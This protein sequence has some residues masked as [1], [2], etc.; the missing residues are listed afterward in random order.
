MDIREIFHQF[1]LS[2]SDASKLQSCFQLQTFQPG[3]VI[4]KQGDHSDSFFCVASGELAVVLDNADGTET[5]LG[6]LEPGQFFGEIG[7]MQKVSR[8]GTVRALTHTKIYRAEKTDFFELLENS[9]VLADFIDKLRLERQLS[10]IPAFSRLEEADLEQIIAVQRQE[11]ISAGTVLCSQ[12]HEADKLFIITQGRARVSRRETDGSVTSMGERLPG[13]HYGD[14]PFFNGKNHS[15]DVVMEEDGEVLIL[16]RKSIDE[17]VRRYPSIAAELPV[18]KSLLATILPF[19]YDKSAYFAVPTLSMNRP[20]LILWTMLSVMFVLAVHAIVPSIWPEQFPIYNGLKVDTDP[21]NML[22]EDEPARVLHNRL[23]QEMNLY[24]LMVVGVV[25][26]THPDGIYNPESLKRIHELTEFAARQHWDSDDGESV[27]GVVS[28]DI[29]SPS[30]VDN[31]G[32]NGPGSISFSWLMPEPPQSR[33]GAL[34]VR[35]MIKRLPLM[36][37]TLA[38]SDDKA[39]AIYL[40]LSAKDVSYRV[41][42]ALQEKIEEF[43][44]DEQYF[45]TGLPVAEDSFG[46]EMFIQMAISAPMAMF[47]IFLLMYF[48]FRNL[49][50]ITAPMVVAM[51]SVIITMSLLVISGQTVHIM[52]SMIPIFI[53]PIA[54]LDSV[55]IL[56]EF[57]DFYPRIRSRRLTMQHVMRELFVP[58]FYTSMTTAIG[59]ASLALVPIPPVQVFGIFVSIGVILAWLLSISFIPAYIFLVKRERIEALAIKASEQPKNENLWLARLLQGMRQF[60]LQRAGM[61]VTFSLVL[62]VGFIYG[63]TQIVVND[64]PIRWFHDDHDISVADRVLNDHFAGT[65]MAYLAF[66]GADE[67]SGAFLSQWHGKLNQLRQEYPGSGV[68]VDKLKQAADA[69]ASQIELLNQLETT[70]EQVLDS[71]NISGQDEQLAEAALEYLDLARQDYQI[72]KQPDMLNYM[73]ELQEHL[74][75]TGIVGKSITITDFVKTVNRELHSAEEKYYRVPDTSQAVAQSLLTYQNSHRPQDIWRFVTNDFR[76]GIV[77]LMLNSGDNVDMTKVIEATEQFVAQNP[78]PMEVTTDWFGLNY[79]NVVWQD[80]MVNGMMFSILGSYLAV[81]LIMVFLLRSIWW[82][83]LAMLPL[84]FTMLVIYGVLGLAGKSYDMPVAVLSALAIGLAIDFAIHFMVRMRHLHSQTGNWE[85]SLELYFNEPAQAI[86][87]NLLVVAI[88]F[89]PLLLAPL[90]PYNTVGNLIAAI[91]FTSGIVTLLIIPSIFKIASKYLFTMADD[92]R[93]TLFGF[94]EYVYAGVV[95]VILGITVVSQLL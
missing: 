88:G 47:V 85:K 16:D 4:I 40:P 67:D 14:E 12:G 6:L 5:T 37:S 90:V 26:E 8:T 92:R 72:F 7:L 86:I 3:D 27:E 32:Q 55:H 78:P 29:M 42:R 68:L 61:V 31:I 48:F 54:V 18:R 11:K 80:K 82:S 70:I 21:E 58:M 74:L 52:S 94:S 69:D 28:V 81:M 36:N 49:T 51:V 35:D 60:S 46:V 13:E 30:T 66:K 1:E 50:L 95:V 56:S 89:L 91:L 43:E 19:F 22:A 77:W 25:N 63:I 41:Y 53:M 59:F 2:D 71:D 17:L 65:Y 76:Q 84:T 15:A 9:P 34:A 45:I 10:R 62:M 93:T 33:E 83:L 44:G 20:R 75:Q 64:N 73:A 38:S 24:D 57:F 87:R 79:I 39:I 23:K